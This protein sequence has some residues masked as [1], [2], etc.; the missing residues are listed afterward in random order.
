MRTSGSGNSNTR[1]G[2]DPSIADG[3]SGLQ[4]VNVSNPASPVLVGTYN[5]PGY[6]WSVVVSGT[7]LLVGDQSAGLQVL[8]VQTPSGSM[9]KG[10]N[11]MNFKKPT[12][13]TLRKALTPEQ[14]NVTQKEATEMAFHND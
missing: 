11:K 10:W 4:I 7:E 5:T 14:Y 1:S 12:D 3:T 6:A 8:N 9:G 13:E 2:G